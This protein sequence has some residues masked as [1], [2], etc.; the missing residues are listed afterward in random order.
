MSNDRGS[1]LGDQMGLFGRRKERDEG[2]QGGAVEMEMY[3][4]DNVV[5]AMGDHVIE[6]DGTDLFPDTYRSQFGKENGPFELIALLIRE[7]DIVDVGDRLIFV[8]TTRGETLGFI[9]FDLGAHTPPRST[10]WPEADRLRHRPPRRQ[11]LTVGHDDLRQRRR[12]PR[13]RRTELRE[14]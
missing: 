8:C 9:P 11:A 4:I 13:A 10:P 14:E 7:P 6:I 12:P 3:E 5:P 1:G 2:D